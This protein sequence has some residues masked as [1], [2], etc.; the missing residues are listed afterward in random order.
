MPHWRMMKISKDKWNRYTVQEQAQMHWRSQEGIRV[1]WPPKYLAYLVILCFETRC[2]KPNTVAHLKSKDLAPQ[3]FWAGYAIAQRH[4]CLVLTCVKNSLFRVCCML[5]NFG[6]NTHRL[7][8]YGFLITT[9]SELASSQLGTRG[10][11]VPLHPSWLRA[12][13]R[14]M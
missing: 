10:G 11:L 4:L 13:F 12:C 5:A 14:I 1:T 9:P 6:A 8:S 3:T 7:I 2:R